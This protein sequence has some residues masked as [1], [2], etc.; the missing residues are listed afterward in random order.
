MLAQRVDLAD[1]V[2]VEAALRV[3]KCC[4]LTNLR[5]QKGKRRKG[6][7]GGETHQGVRPLPFLRRKELVEFSSWRCSREVANHSRWK[8]EKGEGG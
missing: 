1:K 2:K 4:R 6:E 5:W 8:S 3:F 7:K